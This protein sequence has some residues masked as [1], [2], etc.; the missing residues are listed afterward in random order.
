MPLP[1]IHSFSI[2]FSFFGTSPAMDSWTVIIVSL[3]GLLVWYVK[4]KQSF[5]AD[6]G[7]SSPPFKFGVGHS[8]DRLTSSVSVGEVNRKYYED[9]KEDIVGLYFFTRPATMIRNMDL[10][11]RVMISDFDHFMSR[12]VYYNEKDD[13]VS[14]HMFSLSGSKWKTLRTKLTPTFTSGKMKLMF[15]IIVDI[16]KRFAETCGEAALA[17]PEGFEIKKLTSL[18]TTDVIGNCAFGIECNS[19]KEPDNNAFRLANDKVFHRPL[20]KIAVLH[21]AQNFPDMARRMGVCSS[22]EG[23]NEFYMDL[24]RSS[25]ENRRKN[26]QPRNDFMN[27]LLQMHDNPA[28]EA[29]RMTFNEIVAQSFL[30][31]IAGFETSSSTMQF[32]LYELAR[33]PEIQEEAVV[34]IRTVLARHNN[35]FTYEC[36]QELDFL[37]RIIQGELRE[38]GNSIIITS[39]VPP[40]RNIEEVPSSA[41]SAPTSDKGLQGAWDGRGPSQRPPKYHSCPRYSHGS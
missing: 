9:S 5:W 22:N 15:P 35:E 3:L 27:L 18:F 41:H 10:L 31:F 33:N 12:G 37:H 36:M 40:S 32:A 39:S 13:P 23:L 11:K 4:K 29:E 8:M 28:T 20:W 34:H 26:P 19:L 14:A 30:F 6:H 16:S 17:D 38:I 2:S 25:M 21:F 7:I 1:P 24:V